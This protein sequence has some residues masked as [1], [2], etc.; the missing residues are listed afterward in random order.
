MLLAAPA[1]YALARFEFRGKADLW[2]WFISNRMIS[3]I[4]LALPVYLIARKLNMLDTH[5][6][7]GPDLSHVHPADRRVDHHRSVPLDPAGAGGVG[8]A[9]RGRASSRLL[10]HLSAAGAPGIAVSAIFGFIFSWNELLYALVLTRRDGA[11]GAG[12][13]DE[14]MSGYELP[15]GKIMATGTMIVLPVTVF[16]LLVSRHMISGLTMGCTKWAAG[17]VSFLRLKKVVKRYGDRHRAQ[18]RQPIEAEKG[19][20]VVFVGPSGCGKST[21]HAHRS[22]GSRRSRTAK[23]TST[24]CDVTIVAP[25]DAQG[26]DGV[27]DPT[28][29][30]RT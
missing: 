23:S 8:A 30:I 7:A 2:F 14:F 26:V 27:P 21:L 29:S 9:R 6:G 16:A 12:R 25:A 11:D 20:F 24:A 22:R 10:A 4:V 18:A 19:E 15:W 1:A 13:G 17:Q 3:P 28:R 5:T